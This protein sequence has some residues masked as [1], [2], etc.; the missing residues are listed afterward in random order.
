MKKILI[1]NKS[2][3]V[4]GIQ[5]SMIN[6]ANELCKIY[7]VDMFIYNP[8]GPMKE[9]LDEKVN[10]LV[11]S[12]RFKALGMS[13]KEA[14]RSKNPK[15][16][17]FRLF[18]TV[19]TKLF[20]NRLPFNIAIKHQKKLTGYDLAIAFHHEQKKKSV[21]SGFSRMIDKCTDAPKK[22]A[23]LHYDSSM[24]DMD[25]S[26][27]KQFYQKM[28]KIVCVSK[29]LRDSFAKKYSDLSDKTD[30]CYNFLLYDT[31]AQ[32][33]LIPQEIAYPKDK[34]ICFSAC[35]LFP[36]K[37]IPRAVTALADV[38]E[39]YPDIMW[40]IAGDGSDRENI[41]AAIRE[42]S[43]E[44]RIILLGSQNNPYSYMKNADLVLNVSYH[45]AAPVTFFESQ[46]V[47]TPVFATRT[48]SASELLN[49]GVDSFICEN[50]EKEI[51]DMFEK[52]MANRG[53]IEN[54]REALKEHSVSNEESISKIKDMVG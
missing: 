26:Y 13:F 31:I 30:Y 54:A 41:E 49:E 25:S 53:L 45:E 19:W 12:W 37:A 44:D 34:F 4:G 6:M 27:N 36:V 11:P 39:K 28:D 16:I 7:D 1:V 42:N 23:W 48:S 43:L 2:F 33:C 35:R 15:I 20:D 38:F 22:A 24:E 9:R 5:S 51:H 3:E 46:A 47:G 14:L 40:Y 8:V 32:K 10:L 18:S 17:G 50:S 29:S 21:V 52:L